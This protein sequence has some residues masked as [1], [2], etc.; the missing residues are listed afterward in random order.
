MDP[1]IRELLLD[2][3]ERREQGRPA[4]AAELCADC[5]ELLDELAQRI[6][7]LEALAPVLTLTDAAGEPALAP[8]PA[9]PGF[10]LLGEIGRGGMGVVYRARQT[11][12]DRPVALKMVPAGA[13][14]GRRALARFRSEAEAV[15]RLRHANVVRV[16]AVGE[17]DGCPYLALEYCAGGSLDRRL[18]GRPLPVRD[19]AGLTAT[20]ARAAHHC[21]EH[22]VVHRDLKPSNILLQNDEGQTSVSSPVAIGPSET[23]KVADFGL[24]KL[25]DH[26]GRLTRSGTVL[27]TVAYM[28]PEQAAGRGRTVGPAA[29]VWSLGA[30]LYELLTGWP[31]FPGGSAIET[32]GHV[33]DDEPAPLGRLRP[34]C[35][36]D[37]A[38]VCL[39]CLRKDPGHRYP[40][41]AALADDLDGV[42][43]G[44]PVRDRIDEGVV[45]PPG[46]GRRRWWLFG[47]K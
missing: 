38:A 2:W 18:A 36:P 25:L 40:S 24:A 26:D 28:A 32:L 27:G 8:L 44:R 9:V 20:L 30:M 17:H 43:D 29:D 46:L 23:P 21:H 22:G 16:Y 11:D 41:A 39:R 47:W 19:A 10:E 4:T 15:A 6:R 34:D 5:P 31:P 7:A 33:L 14:A 45:P 1:R 42:L 13:R 12:P 37:L 3:E 35:P